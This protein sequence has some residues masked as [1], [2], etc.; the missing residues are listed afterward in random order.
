MLIHSLQVIY[1]SLSLHKKVYQ[2]TPNRAFISQTIAVPL[3]SI[4]LRR[5]LLTIIV[6][7]QLRYIPPYLWTSLSIFVTLS[8]EI[9]A[10]LLRYF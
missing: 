8:S 7:L 4:S 5:H 10:L 9:N 2:A 1:E 3:P 6:P